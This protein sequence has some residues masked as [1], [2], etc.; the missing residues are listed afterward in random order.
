MT[1]ARIMAHPPKLFS[2]T[3]KE[4]QSLYYSPTPLHIL[5]FLSKP[6]FTEA[7]LVRVVQMHLL[8]P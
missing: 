3:D 1:T 7:V 4:I 2:V 5:D 8:Q 6:A